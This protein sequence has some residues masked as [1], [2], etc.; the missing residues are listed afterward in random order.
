[1]RRPREEKEEATHE[2]RVRP[3]RAVGLVRWVKSFEKLRRLKE[4]AGSFDFDAMTTVTTEDGDANG[5]GGG[6]QDKADV[7]RWLKQQRYTIRREYK[8]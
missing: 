3:Y 4:A 8:E 2:K 5:G 6:N 7:L 1:M